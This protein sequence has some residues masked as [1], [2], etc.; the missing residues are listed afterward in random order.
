MFFGRM[1]SI[2][3]AGAMIKNTLVGVSPALDTG[4]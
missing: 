3:V 4:L 2:E 1:A